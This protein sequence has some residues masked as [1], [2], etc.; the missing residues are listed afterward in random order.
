MSKEEIIQK[1]TALRKAN[2]NITDE[3][4]CLL[5][6]ITKDDLLNAQ[7]DMPDIFKTLFGI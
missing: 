4:I 7:I 3:T 5:L 6:G 2:P 1:A